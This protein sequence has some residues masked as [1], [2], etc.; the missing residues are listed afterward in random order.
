[1]LFYQGV[2]FPFL[3]RKIACLDLYKNLAPNYIDMETVHLSFKLVSGTGI[4]C[5]QSRV[6]VLFGKRADPML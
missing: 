2:Q 4:P 1:M 6:K 5:L 3:R